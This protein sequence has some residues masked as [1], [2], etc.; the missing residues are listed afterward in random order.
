MPTP[1]HCGVCDWYF[2]SFQYFQLHL[3][4]GKNRKCSESFVGDRVKSIGGGLVRYRGK[5]F[6]ACRL[7]MPE[8]VGRAAEILNDEKLRSEKA[9]AADLSELE[10]KAVD[11]TPPPKKQIR[12]GQ[13]KKM[14]GS[15]SA[16]RNE[17]FVRGSHS[18][19]NPAQRKSLLLGRW[20]MMHETDGLSVG[21]PQEASN[22]NALPPVMNQNAPPIDG[23]E[24]EANGGGPTAAEEPDVEAE[25]GEPEK[26]PDMGPLNQFQEYI[27]RAKLHQMPLSREMIAAVELMHLMN[28][29]GGSAA[30]YDLLF[31]WHLEHI[32]VTKS[33]SADKL[34]SKLMERYNLG[35]TLPKERGVTLPCAN[36]VMLVPLH[37][38]KAQVVDLLTDPRWTDDDFV[39]HNGNPYA[40]PPQEFLT[41]GEPMTSLATRKTHEAFTANGCWTADGR[42]ILASGIQL[43]GDA[44]ATTANGQSL[45]AIKFTLTILNGKARRQHHAWKTLGF[46]RKSIK[47]G[48]KVEDSIVGSGHVDGKA[49]F[50]DKKHRARQYL[51]SNK[52]GPLFDSEF[53]TGK[54]P[55]K[56]GEVDGEDGST[57]PPLKAQD[58]HCIMQCILDSLKETTDEGGFPFDHRYKGNTYKLLHKFFIH[59]VKADS[60][61]AEKYCGTYG[62][63]LEG[64]GNI[65]RMCC[66]PADRSD[67]V[68][69]DEEPAR[70]TPAMILNLIKTNNRDRLKELS[71]HPIWN[72]FYSHQ[73][74]KHNTA[75]IHG[76]TPMETLHWVQLNMY[77]Y[78]RECFFTQTGDKTNLS[79]LMEGLTQAYGVFL[80]RQS[81]RDLPRTVFNTGIRGGFLQAHEMTG[82]MLLLLLSIR[83]SA[84]RGHLL[85]KGYG[86]AKRHFESEQK[87]INWIRMLETHL[88]FE[89][90][91]ERE[92]HSVALLERAK[93]KVREMMSLTKAV[94][95]RTKGRGH[96]LATFHTT[97]HMPELALE[98]GAPVHNNTDS[99]ESHH[100]WD[101]KTAG[102]TSKQFDTF[103]ISVANHSVSK[104]A[105]ELGMEEIHNGLRRHNYYHRAAFQPL[106]QPE[107][108][109]PE[110]TGPHVLFYYDEPNNAFK[111]RIHSKMVG[112][113]NY[114][115]DDNTKSFIFETAK[116]LCN[117]TH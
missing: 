22:R 11:E 98:L 23:P 32:D 74:G 77:K 59:T 64:V 63:N 42:K 109:E 31:R 82:V 76:A 65:C 45:E 80:E 3:E 9:K 20:R 28:Q 4:G 41:V 70:K 86:D 6:E 93:T 106:P 24:V 12:V 54:K 89:Q 30:L 50:K 49:Y 53:Y 68:Y 33:V 7:D 71:Q 88:M 55:R 75:G 46:V 48:K 10:F 87:V 17:S 34:H 37:D 39:F 117:A 91:L 73:F 26:S 16:L 116:D 18:K 29:H 56:R 52:S 57:P 43:Y 99:N 92:E 110:L 13:L 108:W 2:K 14:V 69:F 111:G 62:T 113:E 101:K 38:F 25:E 27:R 107:P 97:L 60:K 81:D 35:P 19:T 40:D 115:Y 114:Q 21:A 79:G 51:Q 84:G 1:V 61:E 102:R 44:T 66:L 105:V 85:T 58:L 72:C 90:W 94:C 78:N 5:V 112:K 15:G 47:R 83:S 95:Q 96:K 8:F 36:D 67:Q 104:N 100:I 103:E